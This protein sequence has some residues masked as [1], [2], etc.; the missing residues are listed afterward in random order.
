MDTEVA[1]EQ[2]ACRIEAPK[3]RRLKTLKDEIFRRSLFTSLWNYISPKRVVC[4]RPQRERN[5]VGMCFLLTPG[6]VPSSGRADARA[7]NAHIGVANGELP[8]SPVAIRVAGFIDR[9]QH[10]PEII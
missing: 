3:R 10:R 7:I 4:V 2:S 6:A 8:R 1:N 9:D 5:R